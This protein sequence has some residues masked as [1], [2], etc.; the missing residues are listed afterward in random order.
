[1]NSF[2]DWH[3]CYEYAKTKPKTGN[4]EKESKYVCER[5]LFYH[6]R[7]MNH[8]QS[9]KFEEQLHVYVEKKMKEIQRHDIPWCY[10]RLLKETVDI[11]LQCRQTLMYSYVFAYSV[12]ENN[13]FLIF[14]ENQKDLEI[15]TENLSGFVERNITPE[16]IAAIGTKVSDKCVY[17]DK[18]RKILAEHVDEGYAKNWWEFTQ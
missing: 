12:R 13:Q 2:I 1:M 16:N 3:D 6:K 8:N 18:R 14:Q 5:K 9:L 7:Y 10:M 11:L 4:A 15:A 17:C